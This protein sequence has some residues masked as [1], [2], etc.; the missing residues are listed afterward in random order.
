MR[1]TK[2]CFFVCFHLIFLKFFYIIKLIH[3]YDSY[4]AIWN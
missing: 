3:S 4:Q 1:L 2:N